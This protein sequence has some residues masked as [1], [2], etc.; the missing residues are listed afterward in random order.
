MLNKFKLISSFLVAIH[1][2]G[3]ITM[4]FGYNDSQYIW[5]DTS[6]LTN[7]N[8]TSS[9]INLNLESKGAIL[10][11]ADTGTILYEHNSHEKLRPASV[12]KVMTLL[13]A[14]EAIDEG[15]ITLEDRVPCSE[16]ARKMGGSQIWLAENEEL[17]VHEML[18]AICI[19][20]ANDC[21]VAMAEFI[22]GNEETFVEKMNKKAKD[23]G[24]NDTL[25]KNC[26]GIDEDNHL[27]SPT[28]IAIMSRELTVNHPKILEYT[29][30]YIDSLRNGEFGLANTNKLVRN[31]KG[32]TGLKTGSTSLALY[33]L[34]ATASRDGLNLIAVIMGGPTSAIRFNEA[35][36]LLDYGFVNFSSTKIAIKDEKIAEIKVIKGVKENVDVVFEKDASILVKKGEDKNIVQTLDINETLLSPLKKG[37]IVGEAIYKLNEEE[38]SRVNIVVSQDVNKLNLGNVLKFIF[39]KWFILLRR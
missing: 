23:L 39:G 36:K 37:D 34:S 11:D 30:I 6:V 31:Y 17:S 7:S 32:C 8:I 1:I 24:M 5:S 22:A 16:I 9:T 29:S 35:T 20:S 21:S 4:C 14:M 15:K 33:N 3:L 12:T 38:L 13:L 27:M 2:I 18:K 28:D 26:H 25:F 19:V 10:M